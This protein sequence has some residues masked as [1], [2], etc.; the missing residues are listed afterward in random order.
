MPLVTL[1]EGLKAMIVDAALDEDID[2]WKPLKVFLKGQGYQ[3]LQLESDRSTIMRHF[4]QERDAL[5]DVDSD[6][7]YGT[8]TVK[9]ADASVDGDDSEQIHTKVSPW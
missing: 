4:Q 6:S 7:G 9:S 5:D 8:G 3:P 2:G 1:Q